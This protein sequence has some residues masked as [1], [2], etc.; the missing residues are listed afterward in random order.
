[1]GG[2]LRK[3]NDL[4]KGF[5]SSKA[6]TSRGEVEQKLA[7]LCKQTME[8]EMFYHA[9]REQAENYGT[10]TVCVYLQD[11]LCMNDAS[12][13]FSLGAITLHPTIKIVGCSGFLYNGEPLPGRS[14][15]LVPRHS[16]LR[17][18][19]IYTVFPNTEDRDWNQSRTI[20]EMETL[21]SKP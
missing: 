14:M 2:P 17:S 1:M 7:E 20:E 5:R 4:L 16:P 11:N 12:P 9:D 10:C 8:A 15:A 3:L 13:H 21:L 18:L 6:T 19:P